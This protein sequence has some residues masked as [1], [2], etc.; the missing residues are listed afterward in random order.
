MRNPGISNVFPTNI[1]SHGHLQRY[2]GPNGAGLICQTDATGSLAMDNLA[3][4][5]ERAELR[6]ELDAAADQIVELQS[7][8]SG[9]NSRMKDANSGQAHDEAASSEQQQVLVPRLREEL[10]QALRDN[11][12]L[13]QAIG[14]GAIREPQGVVGHRTVS[15]TQLASA[16]RSGL[17][18]Q[19]RWEVQD[20]VRR[21]ENLRKSQADA[22][23]EQIW[24]LKRER[25]H[26]QS[27]LDDA[28]S[29]LR[30]LS[31]QRRL[32]PLSGYLC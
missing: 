4:L 31:R 20:M 3:L 29:R 32:A 13:R 8:I 16:A 21:Q 23:E 26:A 12:L 27:R 19:Q 10:V 9:D 2:V 1:F 30:P 11:E 24:T 18:A 25:D 17:S 7:K 14:K 15:S 22:F 28:E 6:G 5:R